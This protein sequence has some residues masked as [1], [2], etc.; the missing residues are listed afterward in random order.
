MLLIPSVRQAGPKERQ[1]EDMD[2][3]GRT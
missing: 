2:V 3:G 1:Y